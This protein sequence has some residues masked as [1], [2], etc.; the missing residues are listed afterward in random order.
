MARDNCEMKNTFSA[1]WLVNTY[2]REL[3]T[4]QKLPQVLQ[5][6]SAN[7]DF[8]PGEQMKALLATLETMVEAFKVFA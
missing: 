8:F 3:E 5:E 7:K 2:F 6:M 4:F 1:D